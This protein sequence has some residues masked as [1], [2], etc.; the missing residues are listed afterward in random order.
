[1]QKEE[2]IILGHL[3]EA[4]IELGSFTFLILVMSSRKHFCDVNIDI[5]DVNIMILR[6]CYLNEKTMFSGRSYGRSHF[7]SR[8]HIF[9]T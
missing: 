2:L 1:M 5:T 9:C 6:Y 7:G 4:Y 3:Y 8:T